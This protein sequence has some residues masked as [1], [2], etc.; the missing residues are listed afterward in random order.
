MHTALDDTEQVPRWR[1]AIVMNVAALGP[2]HRSFHGLARLRLGG[3][4]GRAVI[5]G[6][7]DVRAQHALH[8]DGIFGA[9]LHFA[10]VHG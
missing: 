4:I 7:G 3:R 8:L 10:P 5:E 9:H 2:A 1:V 6:H